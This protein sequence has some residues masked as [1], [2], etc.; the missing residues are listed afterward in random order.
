MFVSV[1]AGTDS[2]RSP[3][4]PARPQEQD[5]PH[6]ELKTRSGTILRRNES[7]GCWIALQIF[8]RLVLQTI[9]FFRR[10]K[11]ECSRSVLGICCITD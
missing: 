8:I 7:F 9:L 4:P 1:S 6:A 2:L 3:H 10:F 5:R 11:S